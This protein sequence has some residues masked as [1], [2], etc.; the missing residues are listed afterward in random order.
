MKP[1]KIIKD[2]IN[3]LESLREKAKNTSSEE[4]EAAYT[5]FH[6]FIN[7]NEEEKQ[8]DSLVSKI[9]S[10]IDRLNSRFK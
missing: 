10:C 7:N 2:S 3:K 6:A 1:K 8:K 4:Q 5:T 9:K